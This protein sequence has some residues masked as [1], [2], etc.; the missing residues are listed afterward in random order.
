MVLHTFNS[1]RALGV[2]G[3]LVQ[4]QD[5]VLFIEDGVYCLLD[6]SL[7]LASSNIHV[8]QPDADTRGLSGRISPEIQRADYKDF[9][10]LCCDADSVCNW[11]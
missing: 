11:F 4:E 10:Q 7:K 1:I 3:S 6:G 5:H 8:L 9:V 2:S